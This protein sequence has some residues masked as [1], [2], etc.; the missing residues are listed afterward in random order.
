MLGFNKTH[1]I[2]NREGMK[3]L[4]DNFIDLTVTSPPYDNLRDYK[5]CD[6]NFEIFKEVA[7]ELYRVTREG[8][9]VVWIVGDGTIKGDETG[10]SFRQALY[11]KEIGFKLH[12][13]MIYIKNGGLNSGSNKAYIQKTEFM[14]IFAK[15]DIKTY[16]LIEDREN[17]HLETRKKLK[18]QPNG[19]WKEQIVKTK[20]F[21]R[22]YNYW[23][24]DTGKNKGSKDDIWEHPATFPEKLAEDHILSWSNDGDLVLDCFAGSGTVRKMCGINNRQYIGFEI[25]KEYVDI[26]EKR[27]KVL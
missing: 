26:D 11:F 17:K 7:N 3:M 22:R 27:N 14:F 21:G 5:G 23:I 15:G 9:V 8:G 1:C 2:D 4:P 12:D 16:N 20:P 10:T 25:A 6:W 19:E 18:R 24:Y 13:T